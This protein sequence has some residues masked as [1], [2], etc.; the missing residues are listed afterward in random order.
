MTKPS[1]TARPNVLFVMT[2]QQRFD[3]IAA[4]G[5]QPASTP[6]LD[7]LV[8]RGVSCERAYSTC[9]V[10]VPARYGIMTGCEPGRTGWFG[11]WQP[12]PDPRANCGPYLAETLRSLGYRTFGLGKFHTHPRTEPLGFEVHEYSEEIWPDRETFLKDDYVVWLRDKAPAF[13]HLEQVHGERTDMYY[14][15]QARPQPAELC[16]ES[17]LAGRAVEEVGRSDA[18]P[19]FGF[20]SFVQPHPP[21]APPIPYNRMFDPDTM[22]PPRAGDPKIDAADDYLGWMN[23][24]VYAEEISTFQAKQLRARY[25]GAISFIDTC[26]GRILDAVEARPDA[27]NTLICFFSD[28]G[29]LLGDHGAWQKE[30]FFEAST[31]VPMLISWPRRLPGGRRHAGLTTL[32]DL[33]GLATGAAG[34]PQTR[35]GHDLLGALE[36]KAAERPRVIGMHGLPGTK[37]FKAMVREDEWKLLWFANGNR[38][39][40][41]NLREDPGESR[42]VLD[43][44]AAVAARL[45][46]ALVAH[47]AAEATTRPALDSATGELQAFPFARTERVRIKQFGPTVSDF[48][49]PLHPPPAPG[50]RRFL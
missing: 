10:C 20:V 8:A 30:S 43:G 1:A 27:D 3:T 35:Q 39:F 36:G 31:R 34:K 15:P 29:D 21:I 22:P 19:F 23:H 41:F 18:R 7:R 9:P 5:Y 4:L 38:R 12:V 47:L 24:G 25:A 45:E 50:P 16:A 14:V 28:H 46:A 6:N 17:W 26:L 2:D 11:N 40:L 42:C 37:E 48:G 13:E 33:F 32:T 44:H 49:Q